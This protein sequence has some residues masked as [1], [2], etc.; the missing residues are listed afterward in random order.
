MIGTRD[1]DKVPKGAKRSSQWPKVRREFLKAHPACA[2]CGSTKNL[3][4]HHV[5]PF[6]LHPQLELDPS[7]LIA[8]CETPAHGMHCHLAVGHLLN[9]KSFN[10]NVRE[11]AKD[12][13][14]KIKSRPKP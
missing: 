2:V 14:K 7:N 4:A 13:A 11:D 8:L 1:K 5:L 6:H 9:Y 12:W 3:E 10:A